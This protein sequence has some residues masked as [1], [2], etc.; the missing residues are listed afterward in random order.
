MVLYIQARAC[1]CALTVKLPLQGLTEFYLKGS[2]SNQGRKN[3]SFLHVVKYVCVIVYDVLIV[4]T[5]ECHPSKQR[6]QL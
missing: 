2:T 5:A 1:T 4:I 6:K 3:K